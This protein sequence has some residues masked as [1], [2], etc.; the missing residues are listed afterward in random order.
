MNAFHCRLGL[1][2]LVL[3]ST[4]GAAVGADEPLTRSEQVLWVTCTVTL[5]DHADSGALDAVFARLHEL[6][7]RLSVNIPGSELDAV[8]DAAGRSAV[9]VSDDVFFVIGKALELSSLSDGLFDPTVGPL[10]KVWRMNAQD[11]KVPDAGRIAEAKKLV[12]WRDVVMDA[13][14]RTIFL[15]RAGMRL[16]AGG[17]LKGYAADETVRILAA[18]GVTSAIVD[19]GGDIFAMGRKPGAASWQIG[20][21]NPDDERGA[22]IGIASVVNRSVV[23][24]G[25]YEHYF[26]QDGK[27]YHHIMD[28]RTGYPVDNGLTGVTVIADSSMDAD[29]IALSIFCLGPADG[30]ALAKKL[31]VDAIIVTGDH[32]LYL[33]DGA[34]RRLK[35]TDPGFTVVPAQ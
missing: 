33:S 18:H 9:R 3:L 21:Q 29:G 10:M 11:P 24:S 25:V 19:L 26:V 17:L 1:L 28:V 7:N 5:Y 15:R 30:L 14:A 32:K 16:D 20:I 4:V 35:L 31:S 8:S 34:K 2:L 22:S 6:H 13:S 27:R 12:S 23:T